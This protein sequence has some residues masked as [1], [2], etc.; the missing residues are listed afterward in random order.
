MTKEELLNINPWREVAESYD[1]NS[2]LLSKKENV[3]SKD[4]KVIE[5]FNDSVSDEYKYNLNLP[6]YPWYG[7]P[8]TAKVI[9]LS[10]NPAWNEKQI[11]ITKEL[12]NLPSSQLEL[13]TN[14]LKNM[15][16][17]KCEGFL[18][19]LKEVDGISGRTLAN[20]H[21]SYYW[22]NRLKKAFGTENF[23]EVISKFA[24]IQYIAYSSKKFKSLKKYEIPSQNFTKQLIQ[25]II[26]NNDDTIFI[27]PRN[28]KRWKSFLGEI[29]IN[30]EDRF[31]EGTSPRNQSLR[32]MKPKDLEK[33]NKTLELLNI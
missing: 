25:F 26:D 8:L 30:H 7:N 1:G 9:V 29:W 16:Y 13:F 22:E 23:E 15:L 11:E 17:F 32:S 12:L 18:P 5:E 27:V 4:R 3:S 28:I 6:V 14:H 10:Q 24:L 33:V 2:F 31:I 20:S 21:M 19:S